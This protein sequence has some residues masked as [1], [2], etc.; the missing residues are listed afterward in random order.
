MRKLLYLFCFFS[1]LCCTTSAQT[2]FNK[3][4]YFDGIAAVGNGIHVTDSCYYISGLVVDTIAGGVYDGLMFGRLNLQGELEEY[5]L[6]L[7]TLSNYENWET[8]LITTPEGF[9]SIGYTRDSI[10]GI[11]LMHLNEYGEQDTIYVY[12]SPFLPENDFYRPFDAIRTL[13]GVYYILGWGGN[14]IGNSNEDI[15]LLKINE[16]GAQI[17][18]HTYGDGWNDDALNLIYANN[19][20]YVGSER[21]NSNLTSFNITVSTQI[22]KLDAD[23]LVVWTWTSPHELQQGAKD[24]ILEPDGGLIIAS[25]RGYLI[26][27]N[28]QTRYVAWN[29]GLVFKLNAS[30]EVEW[31]T[32]LE[33]GGSNFI[34]QFTQIVKA[35]DNSGYVVVGTVAHEYEPEPGGRLG[36]LAKI[37]STGDSLWNRRLFYY[38]SPDSIEYEHH[39]HDLQTTPDGG[40]FM[41]GYTIDHEILLEAPIQ[42][43]WFLKVDSEG[44]L[45]PGCDLVDAEEPDEQGPPLLLYP[46]PAAEHLNVYLGDSGGQQW[47][48]LLFDAA[49][50][51]LSSYAAPTS[52]TTY[53][54]PVDKYPAGSYYLQVA[55]E[56][57]RRGKSYF[58]VKL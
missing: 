17:W 5:T 6:F 40:Y 41:S 24:M 42:R 21:C 10:M 8:P 23:G 50:R 22:R 38:D 2:T 33:W 44:C 52:H 4:Y 55:D 27:V 53:M 11:Y 57:G 30:R 39:I 18:S 45:I 29:K 37:S 14:P 19:S 48:F 35:I 56:Q 58:W 54:L 49:G 26:D 43:A 9:T 1:I 20:L 3:Q 31:E 47:T 13:D 51:Q 7:D 34:N 28:P 46:N 32:E 25:A 36:Y 16:A 15:V 12:R